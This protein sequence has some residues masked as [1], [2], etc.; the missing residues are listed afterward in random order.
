MLFRKLATVW[1]FVALGAFAWPRVAGAQGLSSSGE[2][3]T[4]NLLA[5]RLPVSRQ[6]ARGDL[7]LVTDG[8]AGPEGAQWDAPVAVILET[9]AGSLTYDLGAVRP[10]SSFL[11]QA[12]ANDTY[13]IFGADENR[14]EAFKLLVEID[15]VVAT[16]GHGLRTR[17]ATIEATPVRYLR[18]G[19]ALGDGSYSIGEFQAFCRAPTPFP[20]KL[21]ITD[22]PPAKVIEAP[23][24]KF[25][26]WENDAS[27][28]FEMGLALGALA[29]LGWGLW[30]A[31]KGM[32]NFR[33]KLRDRLLIVVGLLSFC[34]YWNFFCWHFGN[35]THMW[36]TFHYYVGSKY[37]NEISYD[38]LYECVAVADSEEPGLR[39]RV[40][41][42]KIMNLR[43]NMMISTAEVLA[44]PE[45]CK[46]HFTPERWKDFKHDVGYFRSHHDVKRWEEAQTDHGYNGSPVWNIVGT[47]LSN[48]G[49]A[50]DRQIWYLTRIDPFFILGIIAM[51]WW[52]F[53]WRTMCVALAVFATNFPS[54]FYWTG[55]SLLRWDWLFYFV[56]GFCLIKKERPF[57]GGFFLGYSTLLRIF[58]MFVFSGPIL[59][60]V[61]Q[62]WG[63]A[64]PDRDWWKP[65]PWTSLR[66]LGKRVDRRFVSILGGAALAAALLVPISLVT[67]SGIAG[68]RAFIFN[69]NKHKETPLTNYMG[70]RT[71]VAY[72]P[73]EAGRVLKDDRLED[74]W[75]TWKHTKLVTFHR[76]FP[77]YL[78]FAGAFT[79]LLFGALRDAEPWVACC[80]G[81]TMMAVGVELTCYY[82]S[83]LFA[84]A[85]LYHK[86]REAGAI[87]LGVTAM[88]GFL[89]W[90]PTRYL[91]DTKPWV[92]FKMPQWLDE[93]YMWMSVATLAGF[94]WILYRFG[95][96]PA[97]DAAE[98][99]TVESAPAAGA[100]T[101][102]RRG[103]NRNRQRR[104]RRSR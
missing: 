69:T 40:E 12:D 64:S 44:H 72:S 48:T 22:A 51:S 97:S 61:R 15:S 70:L 9:S 3:T 82:Y 90:A 88:T 39:R 71:V 25:T 26:W 65:E 93:Q 104:G 46:S 84:I 100:A 83:F 101:V 52:A 73:S 75:A 36:D 86:R 81:A 45:L 41:L 91:P 87:L 62:L 21:T 49:P 4:D 30:L 66:A 18:V 94:I 16:A 23:W 55:G 35:Y 27:S 89:D 99:D 96:V 13:K 20:P 67:S 37:F 76:R 32:P 8:A 68:Y 10:V 79:V 1:F 103:V 59:V 77:L 92:N 56:G 24:Y 11:L 80:L 57:L 98:A 28:R 6:D 34:A 14:T 63:N 38:R 29:L 74:P 85:F 102:R 19:E 7:R 50:T 60:I 5:R 53:G 31:K 42:R 17:T 58:P 78:L 95:N 2:C 43:N 54:R 47:T 33:K